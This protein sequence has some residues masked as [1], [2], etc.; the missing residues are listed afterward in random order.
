MAITV[1]MTRIGII[2]RARLGSE[3]WG[4]A[5]VGTEDVVSADCA[6]AGGLGV[7]AAG[8]AAGAVS[9]PNLTTIAFAN[10]ETR[11][12]VGAMRSRTTRV[13][14]GFALSSATRSTGLDRSRSECEAQS[15][16]LH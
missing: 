12:S 13:V 2:Q 9:L 16:G 4:C 8:A 6:S 11:Y 1:V 10:G 7:A 15:V 3:D 14:G 5:G